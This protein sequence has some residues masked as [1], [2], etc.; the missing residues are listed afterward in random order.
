MLD[1]KAARTSL[2]ARASRT[3]EAAS[4]GNDKIAVTLLDKGADVNARARGGDALMFVSL[5][6]QM[7][8]VKLFLDHG[9]GS[10]AQDE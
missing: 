7:T 5:T 10:D 6:G 3:D 2:T 4:L 9:A 8:V 1:N